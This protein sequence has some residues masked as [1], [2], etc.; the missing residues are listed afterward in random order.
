MAEE[1]PG[2]K[3][4]VNTGTSSFAV[5]P[6]AVAQV[7]PIAFFVLKFYARSTSVSYPA[8]LS[9]SFTLCACAGRRLSIF[10]HEHVR[11]H[12]R[13]RGGRRPPVPCP[14]AGPRW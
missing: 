12:L 2:E 6:V 9:F 3:V 7:R 13:R 14:V 11:P 5:V 4:S 10:K 8:L 1:T